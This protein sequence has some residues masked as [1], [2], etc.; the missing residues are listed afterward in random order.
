MILDRAADLEQLVRAAEAA[1]DR[2][3][4]AGALDV[5][6]DVLRRVNA[7]LTAFAVGSAPWRNELSPES[8]EELAI[9]AR[10]LTD[11]LTPLSGRSD[12]QLAV[13]AHFGE[14]TERGVLRTVELRAQSLASALLRAQ[15]ELLETWSQR[16]WRAGDTV[17]LEILR[18]VPETRQAADAA[19]AQR[20]A[21]AKRHDDETA[22]SGDELM[23]LQSI[24]VAAAE[25]GARI[26]G[27]D[28]P[29]DVL[30]FWT[31]VRAAPEEGLELDALPPA[32][33]QWLL[34]HG[35]SALFAVVWR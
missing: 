34:D 24:V 20:A 18:H 3:T 22:L 4:Q 16:I 6:E 32:V 11:A 33:H 35:A 8:C 19:H 15:R 21:L 2:S 25:G 26:A 29:A 23:N 30:A 28:V 27:E 1:G 10:E 5:V 17:R 14:Q 13:Y 9:R 12:E 7:S 31:A